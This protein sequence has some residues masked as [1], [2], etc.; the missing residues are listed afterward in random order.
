MK[1]EQKENIDYSWQNFANCKGVPTISFYPTRGEL[2]SDE[3]KKLCG[4]CSVKN[5]CLEHALKYEAYGFW[6]GTTELQRK[7]IRA[8][9]G[10]TLIKPETVYWYSVVEQKQKAEEQRVKIKGRGRKPKVEK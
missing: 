8:S 10:I 9:R 1:R 2:V 6:G 7:S 5:D 3:L 4:L